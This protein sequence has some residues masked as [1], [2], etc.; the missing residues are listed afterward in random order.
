MFILDLSRAV[1]VGAILFDGAQGSDKCRMSPKH[2]THQAIFCWMR[3]HQI[4]DFYH[5]LEI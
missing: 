4:Y 3:S 1:S 5:V 2:Q